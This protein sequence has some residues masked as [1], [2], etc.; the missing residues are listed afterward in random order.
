MSRASS[1]RTVLFVTYTLANPATVGVF[2]R[3]L[4]LGFEL[5]R[6]GHRVVVANAGPVPRDPKVE[7]AGRRLT[8]VEMPWEGPDFGL[9]E[10]RRFFA[11]FAP[12]LVIF[13]EGPFDTMKMHYRAARGR[14]APFIL[15][16][17]YYQD[18]LVTRRPDI[19]LV[20]LYGLAPFV[21]GGEFEFG[22]RYRLVPPFIEEPTPREALPV[23]AGLE[24]EPWVSI[25]GFEPKVLH[26]G[27]DLVAS[28]PAPRPVA[29]A[30]CHEPAAARARMAEAGLDPARS[31]AL[32]LLSDDDLFGVIAASRA[33][34][35]AN[36][37]MQI[38]EALAL[39]CPAV[40]VMRGVGL[41]GW[42]VEDRFKAYVSIE[43]P[44][45]VQRRRLAGWLA[46]PPLPADLAARLAGERHGARRVADL[47]E[48]LL[49]GANRPGNLLRRLRRVAR[50]HLRRGER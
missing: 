39:G 33:T 15:L 18:W 31:L 9:G 7:V 2:F 3:A 48:E 34:V 38:M 42:T 37:Y 44:F 24:G 19:D 27:I 13:G 8:L 17:Q 4:R 1:R 47:A 5:D 41:E 35:L 6:R 45:E 26:A 29:V 50:S 11:S 36:G 16:D 22:R 46:A 10:A 25:V 43:E 12:D 28:L 30:V 21:E 49:A 14:W 40:V 32:P 20:L 23:P